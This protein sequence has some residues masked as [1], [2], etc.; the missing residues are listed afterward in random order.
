MVELG[1]C[2]L[3]SSSVEMMDVEADS[4]YKRGLYCCVLGPLQKQQKKQKR[5]R[6]GFWLLPSFYAD[7]FPLLM[8]RI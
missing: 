8:M 7:E 5:R 2:R 6:L 3:F 1:V 4:E